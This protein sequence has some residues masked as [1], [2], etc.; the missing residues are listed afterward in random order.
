[1]LSANPDLSIT[2]VRFNGT[3]LGWAKHFARTEIAQLIERH[4][5]RQ[6]RR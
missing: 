3:P 2:D 4:A 1:V 5:R 6:R